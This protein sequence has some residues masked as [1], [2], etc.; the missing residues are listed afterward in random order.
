MAAYNVRLAQISFLG[1]SQRAWVIGALLIAVSLITYIMP[2]P[3][4]KFGLSIA[5][6]GLV[7][8]MIETLRYNNRLYELKFLSD[9]SKDNKRLCSWR[10]KH[11]Q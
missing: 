7:Y 5:A 1:L 11:E 10:G 3:L 8:K 6:L 2:P 4:V 9:K